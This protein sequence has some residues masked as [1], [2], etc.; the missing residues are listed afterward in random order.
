MIHGKRKAITFSYDDGVTQDKRLIEIFNRYG[1][2]CTFN[3]N[4]ALLG[5]AG[6][7]LR[8]GVHVDHTKV[9]PEEI[10]ELYRG[11]EIAVHTLHHPTLTEIADDR[12]VIEEVEAD[13]RALS[14]LC[15]YCVVGM[16]YPNGPHDARVADLIRRKT[17]VKYA[18]TTEASY[19]F[20]RQTDLYHFKPT[21]HQHGDFDRAEALAEEFLALPSDG[22][23][24]RIFYIWG[25][26]YELDIH[27]DW[28]RFERFCQKLAGH[29]D[30]Y[31]GTNTDVLLSFE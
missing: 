11:H 29:D 30:V 4:S 14:E 16:A 31:Y 23:R 20:E 10:A 19:N 13:R 5:H 25:H 28:E 21:V 17:G 15:G 1:L 6:E 22:D 8:E 3:L 2:K 18:R 9:R 24:D 7:L 12:E 26:A 27:N